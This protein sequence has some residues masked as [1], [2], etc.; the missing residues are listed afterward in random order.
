M[1]GRLQIFGDKHAHHFL[2]DKEANLLLVTLSAA[3]GLAHGAHRCF[4]TLS[5]TARTQTKFAH[6]GS[7]ISKCLG[8]LL[9]SLR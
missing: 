2:S 5:M 9:L 7:L 3:K 1:V 4:A 6:R 8:R